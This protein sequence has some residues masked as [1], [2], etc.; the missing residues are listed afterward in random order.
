MKAEEQLNL[1][2]KK[3]EQISPVR[4]RTLSRE[5]LV[6]MFEG[7][8]FKTDSLRVEDVPVITSIIPIP[9]KIFLSI[10]A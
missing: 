8:G 7:F 2:Y 5:K 3:S 9:A 10:G 4:I 6:G 1:W